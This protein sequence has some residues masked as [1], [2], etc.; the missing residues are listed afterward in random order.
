MSLEIIGRVGAKTY[1][2]AV[3]SQGRAS[4]SA[5][6]EP[7]DRHINQTSGKVWSVN[8][9]ALAV[10]AGVYGLYVK[11]TGTK[12]LHITDLRNHCRDAASEIEVDYVSGT[13]AG[14]AATDT[15]ISRNAGTDA[16]PSAD[17]FETSAATGITGLT[18]EG[19]F[20]SAGSLDSQTTHLS[21]SSNII[22]GPGTACAVKWVTANATN[23]VT[24]TLSI[25]EVEHES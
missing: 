6:S 5:A 25:V 12:H 21:T 16:T 7:E 2:M 18:D 4:V 17:I 14:T 3:D 20:F 22:I 10:N 11:N 8:Y 15:T 24:G 1:A 19:R 23:G 9:T 13:A